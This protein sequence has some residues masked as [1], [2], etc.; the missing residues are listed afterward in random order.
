MVRCELVA[1]EEAAEADGEGCEGYWL[2]VGSRAVV[3]IG[4]VVENN[5]LGGDDVGGGM[6]RPGPVWLEGFS[7]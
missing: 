6:G 4:V 2:A 1:E 7:H 3:A 5:L